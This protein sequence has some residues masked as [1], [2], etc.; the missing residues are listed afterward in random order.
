MENAN[1]TPCLVNVCDVGR[2][3]GISGRTVWKLL[4][5]G[6][7][8]EPVHIGRSTRWRV[9]DVEEHIRKLAEE[10]GERRTDA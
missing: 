8:P 9:S 7:F 5:H 2:M 10:R 6:Q 4:Q 3:L 1:I